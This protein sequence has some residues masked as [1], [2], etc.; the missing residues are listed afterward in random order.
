MSDSGAYAPYLNTGPDGLLAQP[1]AKGP[2]GPLVVGHVLA[3]L[4]A[5][6]AERAVDDEAFAPA[7]LTTDLCRPVFMDKPIRADAEVLRSGKRIR[8]VE[9]T[10]VQDDAAT[11]RGRALFLRR[12]VEPDGDVWHGDFTPPAPPTHLPELP[13][14][15]PFFMD[16]HGWG[17]W[18]SDGQPADHKTPEPRHCWMREVRALIDDRPMSPFV[19][20]AMAADVTNPMSNWGSAGLQFINADVTVSL[21]REPVGVDVGI[22]TRSQFSADGVA[23]SSATIFDLDG[24]IGNVVVSSIASDAFKS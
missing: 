18:D 10:L 24:P 13:P 20:A 7:R 19:R 2:W 3:G 15:A 12:G 17:A 11:V 5:D 14:G 23:S 4:V 21:G 22:A 9:V 6:A 16:S 8:L 1:P